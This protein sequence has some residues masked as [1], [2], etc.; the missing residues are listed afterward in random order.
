MKKKIIIICS[1]FTFLL[2][3]GITSFTIINS[4]IKEDK[5]IK[6]NEWFM[7]Q[8]DY[9]NNILNFLDSMDTVYTLY[10]SGN[11]SKKDFVTYHDLLDKQ[12]SIMENEY[13]TWEDEN[14]IK[15]GSQ[16]FISKSGLEAIKNIRNEIKKCLDDTVKNEEP[17]DY[18]NLMYTYMA[19][20]ENLNN[21]FCEYT[22]CFRWLIE[23]DTFEQDYETLINAWNNRINDMHNTMEE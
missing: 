2:I 20:N 17:L 3:V 15:T 4:K 12:Y 21:Y 23:S 8:T 19:H 16:S 11:M 7:Q 13:E 9:L 6:A 10:L 1:I 18:Y 5:K 22:V 14:P